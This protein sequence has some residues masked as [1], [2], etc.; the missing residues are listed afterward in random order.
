MG[1]PINQYKFGVLELGLVVG[2]SSFR[3]SHEFWKF[4]LHVMY[5][6]IYNCVL[7]GAIDPVLGNTQ[8]C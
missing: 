1:L 7:L 6:G 4:T 3:R 2:N 8:V 5:K